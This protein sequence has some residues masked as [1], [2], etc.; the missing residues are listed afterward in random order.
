MSPNYRVNDSILGRIER[1]ALAWIA[2]RLPAWLTPD[3]LTAF[4]FLGALISAAGYVASNHSIDFLWLS[5]LGLAMNWWGDSLDGTLARTRAIERPRFGFFVDQT[6]DLFAQA[7][8]FFALGASRCAHFAISCLGLIALQM[9]LAYSLI[10]LHVRDSFRITYLGIGI[11]EI[12]V[13]LIAGNL[14][15]LASNAVEP[16]NLVKILA[17][18]L[19]PW[20]IFDLVICLLTSAGLL[21][22]ALLAI[23][24]GRRLRWV[25]H[26]EIDDGT[27]KENG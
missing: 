14:I 7:I 20:T 25:D 6:S 27:S 18:P 22:F 5:C 17:V 3:H 21:T 11:T 15:M 10:I 23:A 12:R 19:P 8:L 13:L 9:G 1:P 16:G 4:G 2:Q 24:E 26:G